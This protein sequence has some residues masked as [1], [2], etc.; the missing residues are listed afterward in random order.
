MS[1]PASRKQAGK[2]PRSACP[3][4]KALDLIGD[5]W[6]LLIIRDMAVYGARTYNQLLDSDEGIPTNTLASR[7]KLLEEAGI[8]KR[9]PYQ[10]NPPRYVYELT[11]KGL[12]LVPVL[13]ALRDWSKAHYKG[14]SQKR[15]LV[16]S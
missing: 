16:N 14:L 9:E 1:A 2:E 5:R 4:S 13:R 7:L 10:Q 11:N 15:P 3:V 6:T 12:A 8:T